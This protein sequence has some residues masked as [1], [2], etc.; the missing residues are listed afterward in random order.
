MTF[1]LIEYICGLACNDSFDGENLYNKLAKPF[2]LSN[3]ASLQPKDHPSPV[4]LS[5]SSYS[6][7]LKARKAACAA[8]ASLSFQ[9]VEP[10]HSLWCTYVSKLFSIPPS[11]PNRSISTSWLTP[12][13]LTKSSRMDLHGAYVT[14]KASRCAAQVGKAGVIVQETSK[15]VVLITPANR[16]IRIPK[17]GTLFECALPI[18]GKE[19]LYTILIFGSQ[20]ARVS[21]V[22]RA[23]KKF[24]RK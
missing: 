2:Y 24:K 10:L 5:L 23:V 14:I 3:T 13:D 8:I 19:S 12:D 4:S 21:A 11:K 6:S 1:N 22:E 18:A 15:T 17:E 9:D 7:R 20:I 16:M